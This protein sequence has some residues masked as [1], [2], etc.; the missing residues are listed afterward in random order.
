VAA[1]TASAF[2]YCLDFMHQGRVF[3]PP[4]AIFKAAVLQDLDYYGIEVPDP[5]LIDISQASVEAAEYVTRK[6]VEHSRALSS[7]E[8]KIRQLQKERSCYIVAYECY[9]GYCDTGSLT[10]AL[11]WK[12]HNDSLDIVT[13][14]ISSLRSTD[15]TMLHTKKI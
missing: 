14:S 8:G 6:K 10:L 12:D 15:S 11:P 3:P 9:K 2:R 4:F 5:Y 7:Y 13:F 1:V